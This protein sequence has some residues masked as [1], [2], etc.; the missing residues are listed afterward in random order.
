MP[1][2]P[3]QPQPKMSAKPTSGASAAFPSNSAPQMA[4]NHV[5]ASPLLRFRLPASF[6]RA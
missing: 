1:Q 2:N 5:P 4:S 6:V 3:Y